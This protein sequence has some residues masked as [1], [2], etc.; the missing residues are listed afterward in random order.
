MALWQTVLLIAGAFGL[1][2]GAWLLY[3]RQVGSAP[4]V[5]C[6]QCRGSGVCVLTGERVSPPGDSRRKTGEF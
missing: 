5:G 2:L 1:A 3:G 6:G 4:C